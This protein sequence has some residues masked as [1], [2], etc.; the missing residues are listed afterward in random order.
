MVDLRTTGGFLPPLAKLSLLESCHI[1]SPVSRE[2]KSSPEA[3]CKIT[4][5]G[6]K[7]VDGLQLAIRPGKRY[8]SS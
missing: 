4:G 8:F 1:H 6:S 3:G 7:H 2:P 5:F